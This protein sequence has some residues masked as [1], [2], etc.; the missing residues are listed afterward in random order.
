ML[1]TFCSFRCP[2]VLAA[3]LLFLASHA[4]AEDLFAIYKL[5]QE[6]DPKHRAAHLD[7]PVRGV[8]LGRV[9]PRFSRGVLAVGTVCARSFLCLQCGQKVP[10]KLL[11]HLLHFCIFQ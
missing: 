7:L 4:H 3:G 9:W 1:L 5:A 11:P 2:L 10:I 8:D 6:H